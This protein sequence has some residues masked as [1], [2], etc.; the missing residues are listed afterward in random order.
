MMESVNISSKRSSRQCELMRCSFTMGAAIT[1]RR[2]G[3][4][5]NRRALR[6]LPR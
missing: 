3:S 1:L 4:V 6:A 2:S 5:P